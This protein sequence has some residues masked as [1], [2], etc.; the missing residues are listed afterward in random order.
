MNTPDMIAAFAVADSAR[1]P[2]NLI[3]QDRGVLVAM[4]NGGEVVGGKVVPYGEID[5]ATFPSCA[6]IAAAVSDLEE[7]TARMLA[8]RP[9]PGPTAMRIKQA[10][11]IVRDGK[12]AVGLD[13]LL[14]AAMMHMVM[15]E[16]PASAQ[17]TLAK[18]SADALTACRAAEP[19]QPH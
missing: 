2:V 16:G 7:E 19:V 15:T 18:L 4:Y 17:A 12:A 1:Y 9:L 13:T 6:L 3:I 8:K 10:H 5:G 14:G 11:D